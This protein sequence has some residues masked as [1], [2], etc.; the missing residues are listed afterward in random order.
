MKLPAIRYILVGAAMFLA[1]GLTIAVTPRELVGKGQIPDLEQMVPK[2][3]G[4]WTID[5]SVMPV[6]VSPDV[7]AQLDKI[8]GQ[9]L[10]RTYKNDVGHRVMLSV[11]YGGNQSDSMSVHRP[12]V[13]YT[14][15]GFQIL[16]QQVQQVVTRMGSIPATRLVALH[17]PRNEPIT[18]WITVGNRPVLPGVQQ[19]LAQL[20]YGLTG[21]VPDGMLIRVSSIGRDNAAEYALQD[22]FLSDLI[23]S[24]DA[25][26]RLRL[27]GFGAAQ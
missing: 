11:A 6:L 4:S 8:Y 17:G 10:A 14:A 9:T 20:R 1:A 2:H 23:Q 18:Y 24:V 22:A 21:K 25:S 15:Q 16:S 13:C 3:F 12:E 5:S 7:Q 26:S 19:K 27:A